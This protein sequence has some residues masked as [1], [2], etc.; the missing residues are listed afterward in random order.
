MSTTVGEILMLLWVTTGHSLRTRRG[1][2]EDPLIIFIGGTSLDTAS[3]ILPAH[4]A[5]SLQ[6]TK[7]NETFFKTKVTAPKL[8]NIHHALAHPAH[9]R[10]FLMFTSG[11]E[12]FS[13]WLLRLFMNLNYTS[14]STRFISGCSLWWCNWGGFV[15]TN[16]VISALS[17]N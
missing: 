16:S 11:P 10:K 4:V 8:S 12:L 13:L 14:N 2:E 5:S 7:S 15:V 9:I 3:Q 1:Q 6:Q 17:S